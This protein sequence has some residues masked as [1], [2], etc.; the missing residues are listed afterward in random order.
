MEVTWPAPDRI[1]RWNDGVHAFATSTATGACDSTE[2]EARWQAGR[3]LDLLDGVPATIKDPVVT[4]AGGTRRG[5]HTTEHLPPAAEDAPATA[6]LREAGAVPAR[7][8]HHARIRLEGGHRQPAW[9]RRLQPLNVTRTPGG[10]SGG[11]GSPR[12]SAW[13]RRMSAPT[14]AARSAS[15]RASWHRRPQADVRRV[16]AWLL[17]PFGTVAHPGR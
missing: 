9:P 6:R 16:L 17:S 8:H 4:M 10:S 14:A 13:V 12:P 11:A 15:R 1:A 2:S 7:Q 5:S 3:P